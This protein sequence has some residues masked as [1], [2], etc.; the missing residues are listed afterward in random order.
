MTLRIK[1]AFGR[2]NNLEIISW[3]IPSSS[4]GIELLSSWTCPYLF[5]ISTIIIK[6]VVM[7]KI[8]QIQ[9]LS[10]AIRLY[11]KANETLLT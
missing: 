8:D 9:Y 7:V 11:K 4:V 3:R 6:V 2:D 5:N 10:Q 1:I